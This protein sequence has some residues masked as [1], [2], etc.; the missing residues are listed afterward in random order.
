LSRH[1][2]IKGKGLWPLLILAALLLPG[3]GD[4]VSRPGG[5][6]QETRTLWQGSY[7]SGDQSDHGTMML[8]TVDTGGEVTGDLVIRSHVHE[9]PFD[10]LY[11]KGTTSGGVMSLQFDNSK[12]AYQF[13]FSLQ[14]AIGAGVVLDGSFIHP[15]YGMTASFECHSIEI[16][17]L[18]VESSYDLQTAVIGL[19]FDGKDIWASTSGS[20]YIR[21]DTDGMVLDTV[22]VF[23]RPEV[24]WTSDALTSVGDNLFGH[25]PVTIIDGSETRNESDIEEFTVEGVIVGSFRIGHRTSGLAWDGDHLWSLPVESD[26]LYSFDGSGAITENVEIGVPDLVDVEYDG[27]HFWCVGW[28]LKKLYKLDRAGEVLRAY[29]LPESGGVDFPSGI[30]FDGTYLWY[31]YGHG[32]ES[33]SRIYRLSTD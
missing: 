32:F 8:E 9:Y 16:G 19:A 1:A 7:V 33:V 5:Q 22:A 3:C 4:D 25:L 21:M 10:H 15:T 18:T 20:D 2:Q 28:F 29:D 23:V 27:A 12:I 14:A 31:S 13:D 11:L 6:P 26:N 24:H 30:A 17:T